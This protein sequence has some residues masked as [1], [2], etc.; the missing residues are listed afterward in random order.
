MKLWKRAGTA[1]FGAFMICALGACGGGSPSEA[2]F[3]DPSPK[4]SLPASSNADSDLVRIGLI[5]GV[6]GL[7]DAGYTESAWQ[8]LQNAQTDFPIS[9]TYLET[10]SEVDF[11]KHFKAFTR[12]GV[13]L[14]ICPGGY[15]A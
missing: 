3:G 11:D 14:I 4:S 2:T 10:T 12:D 15:M 9:V 6:G 5:T 8:G 7:R 1:L 13:D